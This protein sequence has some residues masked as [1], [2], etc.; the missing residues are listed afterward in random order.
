LRQYGALRQ[1]D[2]N[3]TFRD[4]QRRVVEAVYHFFKNGEVARAA[5]VRLISSS[6]LRSNQ[7]WIIDATLAVQLAE[8]LTKFSHWKTI[9]TDRDQANDLFNSAKAMKRGSQLFGAVVTH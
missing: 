5:G 3:R 2:D 7:T 9:D 4:A 6:G 1:T 8:F